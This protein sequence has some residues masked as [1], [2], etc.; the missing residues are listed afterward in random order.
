MEESLGFTRRHLL[1]LITAIILILIL[2]FVPRLIDRAKEQKVKDN[3]K[4]VQL[5]VEDFAVQNEGIFARNVEDFLPL[6]PGNVLPGNEG[7]KLKNPFTGKATEPIDG[8]ATSPGQVGY[9]PILD[10]DIPVG[11]TITGFGVDSLI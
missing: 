1:G 2:M 9:V 8:T 3:C 4:T 11:Y 7:K 6:L 10:G 5:A